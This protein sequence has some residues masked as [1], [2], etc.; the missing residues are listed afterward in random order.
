MSVF[1]PNSRNLQEVLIFCFHLKKTAAEA[2]RM[3]SSIYVF[4]VISTFRERWFWCRGPEW[5]WE[6]ENFRRFRIG[7]ITCWK[8]VP[9]A[10]R[11]GRIIGSDLTSHFET[12]QSHG[13]YSEARNLVSVW[14]EAKRRWFCS[15]STVGPMQ[16]PAS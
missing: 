14:V 4:W 6:R 12:L 10:R 2:H 15:M 11:I 8:L 5:R 7:G 1:V 3:L 9:N 13:N 16:P